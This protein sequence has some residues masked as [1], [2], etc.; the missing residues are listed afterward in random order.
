MRPTVGAI[1][2]A[3]LVLMGCSY[4]NAVYNAERLYA[5]GEAHRRGGED[6]LA[7]ARYTD[8]VRK[9]GQALRARADASWAPEALFLLGR[10]YLRLGDLRAAKAALTEAVSSAPDERRRGRALVYL[11]AVQAELGDRVTAMETVG[12]ALSSSLEGP[13]LA[14]AHMLRGHLLL[15]RGYTDQGW[16]DMDRAEEADRAVGVEAGLERLRWTIHHGDRPRTTLAMNALLALP[17]AGNRLDS[18]AALTMKAVD[19]WGAESIGDMLAAADTA[20]WGGTDRGRVQLLRAELLDRAGDESSAEEVA[21]RVARG[22]GPGAAEARLLLASWRA[23]DARDLA[24]VYDLRSSLLPAG[25]DP[26]V[27]RRLV[28]IDDLE[29]LTVVGLEDPLG[30][31][32]AGE[33]A[34]DRLGARYLARGLFLAYADQDPGAPWTPKALL[35]ALEISPDEGDRA[36]L[37]GRLEGHAR[38]PYVLAARG[39]ST[40]GLG[41]LEEDLA[42]RLRELVRQ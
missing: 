33:V 27:A 13:V 9:T 4:H 25:D 7:V 36:W 1:A 37:R 26:R 42:V 23:R 12:T 38:S 18:I 39:G 2:I 3:S 35:A 22:L 21:T 40:A 29:R 31:F 15:E 16:W 32:A 30:W 34:R 24:D 6:S 20:G 14:D 5:Q 28:A 10:S 41:A 19:R 11:A 8:V 17:G